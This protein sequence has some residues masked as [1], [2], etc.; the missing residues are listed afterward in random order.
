MTLPLCTSFLVLH[1]IAHSTLSCGVDRRWSRAGV[2]RVDGDRG[3]GRV[4]AVVIDGDRTR[5]MTHREPIPL[6]VKLPVV[7]NASQIA[8]LPKQSYMLRIV[9]PTEEQSIVSSYLQYSLGIPSPASMQ[10]LALLS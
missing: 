1:A 3:H 4:G 10:P 2:A 6:G 5:A 7:W 9:H 8:P